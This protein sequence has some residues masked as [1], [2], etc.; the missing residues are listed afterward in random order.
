MGV[1][2][3]YAFHIIAEWS[4][5]CNMGLYSILLTTSFYP[6]HPQHMLHDYYLPLLAKIENFVKYVR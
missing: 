3:D 1:K 5:L 2:Y 4:I 6:T